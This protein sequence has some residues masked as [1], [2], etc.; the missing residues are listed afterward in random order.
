MIGLVRQGPCWSSW[1]VIRI[2]D[3]EQ[4]QQDIE[5]IAGSEA[6]MKNLGLSN[7]KGIKMPCEA[8]NFNAARQAYNPA[9]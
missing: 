9:S 5:E 1:R 2:C 8:L 6:L 3:T 4:S 7:M